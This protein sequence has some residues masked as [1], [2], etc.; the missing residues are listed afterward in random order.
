M[1][2]QKVLWKGIGALG[3]ALIT[4]LTIAHSALA[5]PPAASEQAGAPAMEEVIVTARKR[6]ET[7]ISVPVVVS[8]VT[9][10]QMERLGIQ[11]LDGLQRLVPALM[12]GDGGSTAQ[13]GNISIRGIGGA[14]INTLGEQA[15][16]FNFDGVQVARATA[17]RIADVDVAQVDVLK[18]PQA[19]FYGK[20][21]PAGVISV[22]TADPTSALEAKLTAGYEFNAHEWREQGF[23]SGPITDTLG[24]RVAI[25]ASNMRGYSE[26]QIPDSSPYAPSNTWAPNN[27]EYIGRL[28]LVYEPNDRFKVRFKGT[29]GSL[30]S[31]TS[32]ITSNFQVVNCPLG[33]AQP[34]AFGSVDDCRADNKYTGGNLPA[35][36]GVK[37]PRFGDG[38][39]YLDY[40]Q[41]LSSL[42]MTY[43]LNDKL[44]LT[45]V[46]GYYKSSTDTE[47]NI[48]SSYNPATIAGAVIQLDIRET[49]EEVRLNSS[50]DGPFNFVVGGLW[51][52]SNVYAGNPA[53]LS[54][55]AVFLQN[56][57]FWQDGKTYS[58]F[59][60][61]TYLI[62]PT[63]ELAAGAR[64]S[65]ETKT[66]PL[67]EEG[68]AA[69]PDAVPVTPIADRAHFTNTSPEATLTWRPTKTFTLFGGYRQGFLSGGFNSGTNAA[70]Q[71]LRYGQETVK[72]F[73]GGVKGLL[74]DGTLRTNFSAYDYK[75]DGLQVTA[76]VNAATQLYNIG[77]ARIKGLEW[78]GNYLTP[79]EG[80]TLNAAV[81]YNHARYTDYIAQCY[82]GE[83]APGC[84]LRFNPVT[85]QTVLAQ[86]LSGTPLLRA[87]LWTGNAGFNYETRMGA[88]LKLGFTGNLSFT[89]A[90]FTDA[91]SKPQGRQDSYQIFDA[92]IYLGSWHDSWRVEL[93]GRDLSN[94]YYITRIADGIAT[95]TPTGGPAAGAVISDTVGTP[96]R[97]REV[98]LQLTYKH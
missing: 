3:T 37:D 96:S 4:S 12:I 28:T 18:G 14:D 43:K 84:A 46:T 56:T 95:G 49:T 48:N 32:G 27:D 91:T 53:Y 63:L 89:S 2:N 45:S 65:D 70:T 67:V 62:T 55:A 5:A 19:L 6:D 11:D 94:K 90:Y 23:V 64:Y 29:Y 82:R 87:P 25:Y 71:D 60:Q 85:G 24:A 15:V 54:A 33:T 57:A 59:A 88:G 17:R 44:S 58:G 92:G 31:N 83:P 81:G 26:S 42:D 36:F 34:V 1:T 86:D 78:D 97:G 74:L 75:A 80:L 52:D 98:W 68:S 39:A 40:W 93:L 41:E 13:G 77:G 73:E 61:G 51:Q 20:N 8:T 9:G 69:H 38:V 79:I 66:L 47:G 16:S 7:E 50:F 76:T 22:R 21:S 35:S 30:K 10:A 72:G